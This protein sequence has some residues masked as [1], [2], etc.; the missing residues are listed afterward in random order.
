VEAI[1]VF[2]GGNMLQDIVCLNM[3]REGELNQNAMDGGVVVKRINK[4]QELYFTGAVRQAVYHRLNAHLLT[5][6]VLVAHIDL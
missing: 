4:G 1:N 6:Q 3:G 2:V 5:C